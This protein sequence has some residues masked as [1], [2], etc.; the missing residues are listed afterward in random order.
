[1]GGRGRGMRR[2][3]MGGERGNEGSKG[4]RGKGRRN[5]WMR[6]GGEE[7]G[8]R[9]VVDRIGM[10][11]G[12]VPAL[13]SLRYPRLPYT[14]L[15]HPGMGGTQQARGGSPPRDTTPPPP[16]QATRGG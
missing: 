16:K 10:E 9:G 3:G 15:W 13:P 8:R 12:D 1:M 5:E 2:E 4:G 11:P 14:G 6:G 7:E